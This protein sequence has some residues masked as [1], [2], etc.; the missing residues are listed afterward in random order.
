MRT[1]ARSLVLAGAL[2]LPLMGGACMNGEA[3]KQ[4]QRDLQA[5]RQDLRAVNLALDANKS[6]TDQQLE[7]IGRRAGAEG[8]DRAGLATR[9]QELATELRL[10]Q[11]R[12]EE[13]VRA[14]AEAN[15]RS[16]E[17][18]N[19]VASLSTEVVSLEG[20]IQ[21]Q[22]ERVD[23]F[24]RQGAPSG[25]PAA[26]PGRGEAGRQASEAAD[27]LYRAALTDFTKRS[28]EQ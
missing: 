10:A 3:E 20:Q 27:Q 11:G 24:A 25:G 21:A 8:R 12:L 13:S 6:R 1:A 17:A 9:L 7:E 15:R 4:V 14:M 18:M 2:A 28:Y 16:E 26:A 22:Q 23:Q 19:R 5:L